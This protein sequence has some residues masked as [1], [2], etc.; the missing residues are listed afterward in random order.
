MKKIHMQIIILLVIALML[1]PVSASEM[2]STNSTIIPAT[3]GTGVELPET[4][5][6][7]SENTTMPV[8]NATVMQSTNTTPLPGVTTTV[9]S[10]TT[11]TPVSP[12]LPA[13]QVPVG[14]ITVA[15]SPPGAN[16]LIDGVYYRTAPGNLTGIPTG[17]HMVRLA[18][19][20]YYDMRGS[21]TCFPVRLPTYSGHSPAEWS[22]PP[23]P[24][25]IQ[26][27]AVTTIPSATVPTAQSSRP[28]GHSNTR[29]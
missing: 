13:T 4:T 11:A 21:S 26:P 28:E 20:G 17:N 5:H 7:P 6:V 19:S 15:S 24:T 25:F 14:N 16:I 22:S 1:L 2:D 8:T 10:V 29:R 18:L 12:A 23:V 9:L 3:N 27:I